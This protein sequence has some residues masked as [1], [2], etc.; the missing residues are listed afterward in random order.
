[1]RR[2]LSLALAA[3]FVLAC[4]AL[5]LAADKPLTFGLL[6]VGP[7]N[8]KGY[9]QA[10]Y[11]GGKY[12]EAHQPGT[13]MLYLDKVNPADRPG[14]TIP[15]LVDDLVDKGATLILAGSDDMKDGIREAAEAHPDLTFV[16]LSGDDALT[17]KAPKNL[18][19]VFSKMEYAKMLAGFSAAMTTKTGKI[20]FLG[21]LINDETRRLANAAY[22]GARYAWETVRGQKP[23]ALNFKVSW[24]GFWFNIPGVTSD[25][26]QVAGSFFDQGYDVVISGIDTP[27]ALTVAGARKKAGAAVFALPYDYK[28]ACEAAPDVCLGVPYFNWGPP[29]LSIVKDVA[30]GTYKPGFT[31]LAPDFAA[32]NNP[33][34][35]PIGFTE[36][37]ALSPEAKKA[38]DQFIADLGTGKVNL[39]A[40]PLQYQDGTT[41]VQAGSVATDKDI[42]F[43]PQ[44]LRGIE[45]ASA[46]K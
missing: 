20:G 5:G 22:L 24:I 13:K 15:Q 19:N 39:Y 3:V 25:P 37:A 17:G 10:Q 14:V 38:L 45:G 16:H 43:C 8:D 1:M 12:V 41:F 29:L 2:P 23:E 7:Y 46:S 21:P 36:G 28:L 18:G 9:S 40:G 32:L 27:E 35:S 44:L 42:W 31:W 26:N 33:D 34:K 4:A 30:A 11:E 6:L